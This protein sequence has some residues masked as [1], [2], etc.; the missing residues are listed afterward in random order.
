MSYLHLE[1]LYKNQLILLLRECFALEKI[2]GTS[3]HITFK[4]NPSNKSQ[5][6]LVFFSGGESY[7]NFVALFDKD[8]LFKQLSEIDVDPDKDITIYGE[9][10]GGKQ[11]GMT[12]TYGK[13]LKFIAFDVQ[14]GES[15]LDVLKADDFVKKLDLEFVPYAKSSTDLKELDYNRDL[16]SIQSVRN[17]VITPEQF[18]AASNDRTLCKQ[19]CVVR[20]GVVLRPLIELTLNNGNRLICKHKGDDFKETATPRPV[21]DPA[22]IVVLEDADKVATEWCV[23]ERLLHVLDKLP[24]HCM[25]RMRDI[26]TAMQEDVL[27][28]GKGEIVE[29]EAVKK[30]IGKKTVELY[31][32][33]VKS[34]IGT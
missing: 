18:T 32:N 34:K 20:E 13:S 31:K 6:Q 5:R 14:I 4:S 17:G 7:N 21:V 29:S 30:A 9:A 26:I 16:P 10:Y 28:E 24:G 11:Q 3:A 22:K 27:R 1:N 12:A 19:L 15:W 2:H 23:P 8:K 25:E 33:F